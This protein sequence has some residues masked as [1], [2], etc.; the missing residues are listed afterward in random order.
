MGRQAWLRDPNRVRSYSKVD[1]RPVEAAV[2]EPRAD[3]MRDM[4]RNYVQNA[5]A[6][7]AHDHDQAEEDFLTDE[8]MDLEYE[9]DGAPMSDHQLAELIDDI[10]H[11]NAE[12]ADAVASEASEA[13]ETPAPPPVTEVNEAPHST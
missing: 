6:A 11:F 4:V 1:T 9:M 8:E 10:E 5:V 2:L 12:P 3:T 13:S 7:A